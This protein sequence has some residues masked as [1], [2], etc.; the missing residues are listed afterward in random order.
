MD[1]S[2]RSLSLSLLKGKEQKEV[3]NY[4]HEK[5][6]GVVCSP[7]KAK[8]NGGCLLAAL[9]MLLFTLFAFQLPRTLKLFNECLLSCSFSKGYNFLSKL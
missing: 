4:I 9:T 8:V 6:S 3:N 2:M 1:S 5:G 7:S